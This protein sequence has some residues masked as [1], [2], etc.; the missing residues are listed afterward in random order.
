MTGPERSNWMGFRA[1]SA[2]LALRLL[3]RNCYDLDP[4]TPF[5]PTSPVMGM[6]HGNYL[7]RYA[8]GRDVFQVMPTATNTAYTEFG[9]PGPVTARGAGSGSCITARHADHDRIL[10][11][12]KLRAAR[13]RSGGR[14]SAGVPGRGGHPRPVRRGPVRGDVRRPARLPEVA[15]RPAREA[16][17]S[18]PTARDSGLG[19]GDWADRFQSPIRIPNPHSPI[20]R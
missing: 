8:D 2:S 7:F 3:N 10:H 14:G 1:P 18:A 16:G 17:R 12:V 15:H 4:H 13:R 6:G 20:P 5:L 11:D 19:I 9:C